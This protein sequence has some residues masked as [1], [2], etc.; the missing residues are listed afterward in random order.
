MQKQK[1][2]KARDPACETRRSLIGRN[3]ASVV[4]CAGGIYVAAVSSSSAD[5]LLSPAGPVALRQHDHF[6]QVVLISLIVVLPVIFG[7]PLLAWRYRHTNKAARYAPHWDF[8]EPLEWAMW[9][10]P[11]AIVGVLGTLLWINTHELDPYKAL[12]SS[13]KPLQVQVVGLDWKWLFIYPQYHV[14][15]VGQMAFPQ[16]RPVQ[17]VLTT[18][19]VMQSFTIPSLAG[20]IYAMPGMITKLNLAAD[21]VGKFDGNNTQ[22][23]G[24][25]F[26]DQH[27][28]AIS[29]KPADFDA[30]MAKVQQNGTALNPAAYARLAR[31]STPMEVRASFG[32]QQMPPKATYF[33]DVPSGLFR[34]IVQRYHSGK[35]LMADQQPGSVAYN[36]KTA[37]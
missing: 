20:Q 32:N 29:M 36:K 2:Q 10:V 18:D 15:T 35:P 4:A 24:E 30:W 31:S 23:S 14:A 37:G 28:A 21:R 19:T 26:H 6:W 16:D 9:L 33:N 12:A 5:G 34:Q 1:P 25:G 27:F 17:M 7:V 13:K 8:S 11:L 3:A 22:Y